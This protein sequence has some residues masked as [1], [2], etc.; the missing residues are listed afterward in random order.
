VVL[1]AAP[2]IDASRQHDNHKSHERAS[3][4]LTDLIKRLP[5][6]ELHVHIEGTLEPELMFKL[7]ERNNI[8]LP[9]PD[10]AAAKA[11]RCAGSCS[12]SSEHVQRLYSRSSSSRRMTCGQHINDLNGLRVFSMAHEAASVRT[13]SSA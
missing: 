11:A 1:F 10:V 3:G 8:T 9:Y 4:P 5:K 2:L 6:A 7:A 12:G 13:R